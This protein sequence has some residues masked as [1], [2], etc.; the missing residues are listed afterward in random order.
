MNRLRPELKLSV[1]LAL[2]DGRTFRFI[3]DELGIAPALAR[4][5]R[6]SIK[7]LEE[8]IRRLT[9]VCRSLG[10][11]WRVFLGGQQGRRGDKKATR[12]YVFGE[13]LTTLE[14]AEVAGITYQAMLQRLKAMPPSRAITLPR[15][16]RR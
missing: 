16:Q 1:L 9:M 13:M 10:K 11:E 8:E 7:D 12:H 3:Q 6:D 4:A 5:L 15:Y 2:R 14:L